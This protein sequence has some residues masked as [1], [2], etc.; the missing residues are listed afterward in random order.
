MGGG[1]ILGPEMGKYEKKKKKPELV[2]IL[3][4]SMSCSPSQMQHQIPKNNRLLVL[5]ISR[6]Q[7]ESVRDDT[8]LD[9]DFVPLILSPF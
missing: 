6:N 2:Y 1:H 3:H 5:S 9:F 8:V 7:S 4:G